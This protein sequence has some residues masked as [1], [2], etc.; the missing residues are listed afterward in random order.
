MS[1]CLK[2]DKPMDFFPLEEMQNYRRNYRRMLAMK[3]EFSIHDISAKGNVSAKEFFARATLIFGK[4]LTERIMRFDCMIVA[5]YFN[6]KRPECASPA[7]FIVLA[8]IKNFT[9]S[10][11]AG[12]LAIG[13]RC[14]AGNEN[15][16]F[17]VPALEKWAL[18]DLEI[19]DAEVRYSRTDNQIDKMIE[20]IDAQ[21]MKQKAKFENFSF[22]RQA[23]REIRIKAAAAKK[24]AKKHD[25]LHAIKTAP[26]KK[27]QKRR[28]I[29]RIRME[30]RR[31]R[32]TF[33]WSWPLRRQRK[34]RSLQ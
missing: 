19:V 1:M 2:S 8:K 21:N 15:I 17:G 11:M 25:F 16:R 12:L 14:F 22:S 13:E 3:I 18:D 5:N 31:R 24:R 23:E 4:E 32:L 20:E 29:G 6:P 34:R 27:K 10:Q 30:R 7:V 26:E 28:S 33:G 9:V